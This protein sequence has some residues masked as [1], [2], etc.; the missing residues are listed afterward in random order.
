MIREPRLNRHA[1]IL[2][3]SAL[4]ALAVTQACND[5]GTDPTP[6]IAV[7][8]SAPNAT[9]I[10]GESAT[11]VA[12]LSG[13]GGFRGSGAN[14]TLN[15]APPGVTF[16]VSNVQT[17]G[18]V[19]TATVTTSVAA[20]VPPGTYTITLT[21]SGTGVSTASISF[22]LVVLGPTIAISLVPSTATVLQGGSVDIVATLRGSGGFTGAGAT[23]GVA[24]TAPA[25][26]TFA[27]TNLQTAGSVTTATVTTF[28]APT[29][30]PGTYSIT[31]T[32]RGTGVSPV[33][34]SFPITVV[35][36]GFTLSANPAT[37]RLFE[38]GPALPSTI[39][40]TRINGFTGSVTLSVS[41][42]TDGVG[43]GFLA[44]FSPP[45]T[46]GNSSILTV[47]TSVGIPG[48]YTLRITGV[49][50]GYVSQTA[51]IAVTVP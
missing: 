16:E 11:L 27:V 42:P 41:S 5:A 44:E 50:P 13:S 9:V 25:G 21:G 19:T 36:F 46:T 43:G 40:I 1:A 15:G 14:F 29:V 20:T 28:V 48:I 51:T 7:S 39:T 17:I 47:R 31:L 3:A 34:L 10:R 12:T 22:D 38:G 37:L 18:S 8:I 49:A 6:S 2:F 24:S 32:G 35:G 4:S 26:V 33:S 45:S 23:F 30:S